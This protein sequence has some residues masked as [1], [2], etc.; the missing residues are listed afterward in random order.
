MY[1]TTIHSLFNVSQTK[2]IVNVKRI[3][4]CFVLISDI[5]SLKLEDADPSDFPPASVNISIL[6]LLSDL[7]LK[8]TSSRRQKSDN[9]THLTLNLSR[10]KL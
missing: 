4:H 6:T 5:N 1:N 3:P 9:F 7:K 8:Y 2:I 10:F